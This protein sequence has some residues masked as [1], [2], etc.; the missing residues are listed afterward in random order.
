MTTQDAILCI[1]EYKFPDNRATAAQ[2]AEILGEKT[3]WTVADI[4][5]YL[6]KLSNNL[7]EPTELVKVVEKPIY[8]LVG[9]VATP[10]EMLDAFLAKRC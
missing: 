9:T 2:I 7:I 10:E 8:K 3:N 5:A 4:E 6:F 1:L